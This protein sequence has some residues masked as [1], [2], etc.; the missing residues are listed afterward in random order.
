MKK[1]FNLFQ[2]E[3]GQGMVEYGLIIAVVALVVVVGLTA[4]GGG[5]DG[6][7]KTVNGKLGTS[8]PAP[9]GS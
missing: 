5:L 2:D 1:L 4:L 6:L 7:F 3:S 9:S 8:V